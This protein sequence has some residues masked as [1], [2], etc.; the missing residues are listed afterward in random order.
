MADEEESDDVGKSVKTVEQLELLLA[1]VQNVLHRIF[2]GL[3][4]IE[5]ILVSEVDEDQEKKQ[6]ESYGRLP[7]MVYILMLAWAL[8]L[9]LL[10]ILHLW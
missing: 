5:G 6:E 4:I 7:S 8:W 9:R 1:D 2:Y 10:F 3:R